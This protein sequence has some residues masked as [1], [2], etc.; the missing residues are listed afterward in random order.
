LGI[1]DE[2]TDDFEEEITKEKG[3]KNRCR[4]FSE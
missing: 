4:K 2:G 1:Y 3:G